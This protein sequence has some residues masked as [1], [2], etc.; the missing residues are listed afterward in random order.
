M[1]ND[2]R[3]NP[4]GRRPADHEEPT[5]RSKPAI[6]QTEVTKASAATCA[7]GPEPTLAVP[8]RSRDTG[9]QRS[10]HAGD[11]QHATSD[12][13]CVELEISMRRK[14]RDPR[15]LRREHPHTGPPDSWNAVLMRAITL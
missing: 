11:K 1:T 8:V 4:V 13:R 6:T 12:C 14:R 3:Q 15:L 2:G 9:V 7:G 10:A 5:S